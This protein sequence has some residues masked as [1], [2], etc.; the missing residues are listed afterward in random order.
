M[1]SGILGENWL[2]LVVFVVSFALKERYKS[3]ELLFAENLDFI[4]C[5]YEQGHARQ[6]CFSFRTRINM[7]FRGENHV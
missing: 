5:D 6:V 2:I 1:R 4:F 3:A 7:T